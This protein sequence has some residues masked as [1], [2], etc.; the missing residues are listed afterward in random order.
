MRFLNKINKKRLKI[1]GIII[2]VLII[3]Y[4]ALLS[5][6]LFGVYKSWKADKNYTKWEESI[7]EQYR[8]DTYG[9]DTP[10]ETWAM[11]LQALEKK[12]F[13]LASKYFVLDE[14][15]KWFEALNMADQNNLSIWLNELKTLR[16]DGGESI[17][18][19]KEY[20]HYTAK[21]EEF[22]IISSPVVFFFNPY[23]KVWKIL[24][25]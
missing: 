15:K 12:D 17:S 10:E 2:G 19:D 21:T 24:E 23:S 4:F 22:G 6:Q 13:D 9:G 11:F 16:K 18:K 3:V 25:I 8:N 7:K 1:T 5:P 20:Y 14:Q